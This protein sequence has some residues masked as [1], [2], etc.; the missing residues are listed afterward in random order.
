MQN[1]RILNS[2]EK[3]ELLKKI[4][5]QF[6]SDISELEEYIFLINPRNKIFIISNDFSKI[7]ITELRIN[8]LG[9][10]F[11]ELYNNELRLS[12]EGSQIIGKSAKKNILELNNEL[13]EQWLKGLD[14]NLND[15][16][17]NYEN[18]FYLIKNNN[19]FIGCGKIINK[20]LFN[21]VPKER[22]I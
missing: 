1:L 14:I 22:R 7:D 15:N 4:K 11:G 18:G 17:N 8:S 16:E 10:Y 21:Y 13:A 6:D 3:K 5:E 20:K 19:I 9:L 2:K 12:I